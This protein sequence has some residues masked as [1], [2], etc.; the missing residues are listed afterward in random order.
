MEELYTS[1][2]VTKTFKVSQLEEEE[3]IVITC[4]VLL[5][6]LGMVA[7]AIMEYGWDMGQLSPFAH[8]TLGNDSGWDACHV[9]VTNLTRGIPTAAN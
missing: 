7:N 2:E 8:D 3:K 1:E 6:N 4:Q 9:K 5:G